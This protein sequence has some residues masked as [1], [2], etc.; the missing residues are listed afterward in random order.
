MQ[1]PCW[2]VSH[3][4]TLLVV[5]PCCIS[6]GGSAMQHPC[7]RVS[8]G[9]FVLCSIHW[10]E[11]HSCTH[12]NAHSCTY[13]GLCLQGSGRSEEEKL[14]QIPRRQAS[15]TTVTSSNVLQVSA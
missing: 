15:A 3:A 13:A 10:V 7:W 11:R 1:H 5:Q 2:R 6:A 4:E 8:H 12:M 9:G 14:P